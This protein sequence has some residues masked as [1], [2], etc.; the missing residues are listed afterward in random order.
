MQRPKWFAVVAVSA[1]VGLTACKKDEETVKPEDDTWVP[2]EELEAA[3]APA[4]AV[5]PQLSE[6]ERLEQA[7]DLYKQAEG[8]AAEEDWAGALPLYEQAYQ[9]VPG[10]HGFALKVGLAAEKAG[11]CKKATTYLE[12]FVTYATE[13][14]Y[15]DDRAQAEALLAD[16]K[17]RGC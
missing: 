14:K 4:P 15:Q 13:D 8:K 3:N 16:I 1:L 9:L 6:E 2:D 17:K 5:Q 10:K 11:D 12:H 7:K